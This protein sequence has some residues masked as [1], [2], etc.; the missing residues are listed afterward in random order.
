MIQGARNEFAAKP[1]DISIQSR[2]KALLDLQNILNQGQLQPHEMQA[3]RDQVARIYSAPR[4]P[5]TPLPTPYVASPH[6]QPPHPQLSQQS[7]TQPLPLPPN[8]DLQAFLSSNNLA[9]IIAKAQRGSPAPPVPQTSAI[10]ESTS[11]SV[12]TSNLS[13]N[14]TTLLESLRTSGLFAPLNGSQDPYGTPPPQQTGQLQTGPFND[15]ILT[16]ASLKL[17]VL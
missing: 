5:V 9:D 14:G 16:T 15:V 11:S 13:C 2:L 17:Y 12:P 3:V 4:P 1:W 6:Q 8:T 10:P 7:D